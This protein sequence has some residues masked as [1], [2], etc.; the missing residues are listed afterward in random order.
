MRTTKDGVRV[1]TARYRHGTRYQARYRGPDGKERTRRFNRLVD[2]KR[3]A[4]ANSADVARGAWVDPESGKETFSSFAETWLANR[5]DLRPRSVIVYRSLLDV[6][7]LPT[8]GSTPIAKVQPSSVSTWYSALVSK[9]PGTAP[10]AYRL[11]RAIFASAVRDEKL[12][13]SPCRVPKGGSDRAVERPMLTV[14]EVQALAQ[15]LPD[16][17][18]AAVT[19]AA[20]GALRRGEVLGLRRQDVDPLSSLVRVQQAQVELSNGSVVFGRPKTDAGIRTI[21]LPEPSMKD[22]SRHMAEYVGPEPDALLFTGLGGVPM[23]PKTLLTAW[24]AAR[25]KCQLPEARFHDLR[26]FALTMAAMTGASTKE[27]MKRAGH[28]SAAAALRYQHATEERDKAIAE[29]LS[30]FVRGAEVVPITKSKANSSRTN[31]GHGG[32]AASGSAR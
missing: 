29:A 26:H 19:L 17:L 14:A 24:H 15:A 25:V 12:L 10:A 13:R 3:W 4:D 16:N 32:T 28:R 21:H 18:R 7:L 1:R 23:R 2:A 30:P 11:L 6:H 27:L 22:V 8:F 31:N 20:W 9:R 5:P